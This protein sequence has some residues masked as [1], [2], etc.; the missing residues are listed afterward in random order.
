[1]VISCNYFGCTNRQVSNHKGKRKK[2]RIVETRSTDTAS[3]T[4]RID[5]DDDRCGPDKMQSPINI[6][7]PKIT[8]HRFPNDADQTDVECGR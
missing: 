8:F 3:E 7:L 6:H 2:N 1:M 5:L 4:E